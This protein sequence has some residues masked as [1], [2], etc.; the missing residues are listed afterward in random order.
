MRRLATITTLLILTV[1]ASWA[2]HAWEWQM[3]TKKPET[4]LAGIEAGKTSIA[5]AQ[6]RLGKPTRFR[7]LPDFPGAAEY[8]WEREGS[9]LELGTLFDEE[10]RTPEGETVYS[11]KVSGAKATKMY[12]TGAGIGLGDDLRTLIRAYGPVYQT[13]WR[14]PTPEKTTFT[15]LFRDETELSAG[16]SGEGRIVSIDLIASIE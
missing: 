14:P 4:S 1:S 15:F 9:R 11:V 7:D 13:S 12:R 8:I 16:L 6:K 10:H 3:S 2:D 5:E